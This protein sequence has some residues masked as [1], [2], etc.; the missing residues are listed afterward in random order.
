MLGDTN[1][2]R[3]KVLAFTGLPGTGKSTLAERV[4]VAIG[5]PAFAGD[6]LMGALKPHGVLD[7]LDRPTYLAM[8]YGL[9]ET[10]VRRQL[11]VRQSAITDCLLN[12]AVIAGWRSA[13]A[14]YGAELH[15]V[16]CVCTDPDLH[17]SRLEGRARGIPGWH[18]VDWEHV[19]RM[20]VAYP[21]LT[22]ER[23]VIDAVDPIEDNVRRV[24]THT[25]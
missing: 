9:L 6:W 25:G 7:T 20:R 21:P 2:S 14:E 17:R 5:A 24:L 10:L 12:D 4:A 11:M 19:H 3:L 15:V 23:L 8:Y 18:E 13:A 1:A 16:E 22:V